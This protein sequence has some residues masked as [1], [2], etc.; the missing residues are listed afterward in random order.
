MD[1]SMIFEAQLADPTPE[2]ERRLLLDS[3][4][5]AVYG[6]EMGFDRVW[7]VEHHGLERY[8]HM[9]ASEIFLAWVAART[10]RIRIGH[11]V[12]CMPFNYNHPVRVAERAGML[13]ALSGGRLD[14]GGGRGSTRMEMGMYGVDPSDTYPQMEESLR[15]LAAAWRD[16]R[17]DWH[18]DLLDVG[19]AKILPRPVQAPHPPLY[20]ACSKRDTVELAAELGVG[21]LVMGFAGP[22]EVQMMYDLYHRRIRTRSGDRL[23]STETNDRFVALCPTIVLDDGDR[24]LRIGARGQRFFA[25]AIAHWYGHGPAPSEDTEDDDNIAALARDKEAL[26]AKLS[27]ANIP[28]RPQ[29]TGAFNAEHAYGTADDAIEYVQRLADIGVDEIMCLIQMGTVPQEACMETIRQWGEKVIPHFRAEG[30][31]A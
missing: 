6:E 24:A 29:D 5:Q 1:F 15:F 26:V 16:E 14:L 27:E 17:V 30:G 28:A 2:R 3:V 11:G 18:T 20:M 13:D 8:A 21:A 9:T 31:R 23:V 25:E 4:E 19:P 7:A 12:V 10:S 22:E